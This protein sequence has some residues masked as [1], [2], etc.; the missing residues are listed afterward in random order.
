MRKTFGKAV[1]DTETA[2][3]VFK[4]THGYF[5]DP[6]HTCT[7]TPEAVRRY[8]DKISGPLLDRIDIQIEVP[9]VKFDEINAKS[10]AESSDAVRA[11]VNRAREFSRQRIARLG[12][13]EKD[14]YKKENCSFSPEGEEILKTAFDKLLLSARGYDRIVKVSRTIADLALSDTVERT[15]VLEAVQLRSLDRKYFSNF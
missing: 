1:Y 9:A 11:R 10:N 13:S 5:G 15:H 8:L 4:Y 2:E 12:I 14:A 6:N 3:L 7:C